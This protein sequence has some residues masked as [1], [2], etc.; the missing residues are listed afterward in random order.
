MKYSE[1]R[2]YMNYFILD[3]EQWQVRILLTGSMWS[4]TIDSWLTWVIPMGGN[5]SDYHLMLL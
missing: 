3:E 5:M 2:I 4:T 1:T